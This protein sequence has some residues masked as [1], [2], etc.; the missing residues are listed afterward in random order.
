MD[1][2]VEECSLAVGEV[3]GDN[4]NK[5]ASRMNSAIVLFLETTEKVN[6][7]IELGIVIKDLH[8]GVFPLVNLAKKVV[9]SNVPP[10]I[11]DEVIERK[12]ARHRQIVSTLKKFPL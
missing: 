3:V 4:C 8:I 2:S 1:C 10:F 6:Q 12:L 9:I 5:L 7:V 11:S